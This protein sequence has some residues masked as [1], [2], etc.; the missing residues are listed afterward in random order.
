MATAEKNILPLQDASH[1]APRTTRRRAHALIFVVVL[2]ALAK[3]YVNFTLYDDVLHFNT[4]AAG[5]PQVDALVPERGAETL[6]AFS[7]LLATSDF[8]TKAINWLA[9]AVQ[10][11]CVVVLA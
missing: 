3:L 8:K 6:A 2:L 7:D 11:P 4:A 5:C 10:V 1:T 9:G